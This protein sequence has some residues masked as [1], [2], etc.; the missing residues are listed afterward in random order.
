[1]A[2]RKQTIAQLA[3]EAG[4]EADEALILLWDGGFPN[5]TGPNDALGKGEA[6]RARRALGLATRRELQASAYWIKRLGL[7]SDSDLNAVLTEL[8]VSRPF[9]GRRLRAKAIHRLRAE[10]RRRAI[11]PRPPELLR[12]D[13]RPSYEPLI[14]V[15][16]GHEQNIKPLRYEDVCS[17]HKLLVED[18]RET[19]DPIE[20]SG[21]RSRHLLESALSRP[22]TAI[23][24]ERKYP[25][26]EMAAAALLHS[27]VHDHPFHNGNKR[28]ALVSMLVLLDENGMVLTCPED[29]L[30]KLV[31]KLAQHAIAT[32]PRPELADREVLVVARWLK[33]RVRWIEKGDRSLSWRRLK[34]ILARYDCTFDYA[35]VGNRI[36]ITRI[37]HRPAGFFRGRRTDTVRTQ[38]AYA[39]DGTEVAK[40]TVNKIRRDLELDDQ[41]GVDSAA[42]YDRE[43]TAPSEFIQRYRKTLRRLAKL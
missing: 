33:G 5:V 12:S 23:G 42:F 37:V 38:T 36:N 29:E 35:T 41:H 17:I 19:S 10:E 30:F 14:W 39:G 1:M 20:P 21:V 40:N 22:G 18:F 11:P 31:L 6:N 27:L 34:H 25:T 32:G 3:E 9:E 24:N 13:G 15:T 16:V 7:S 43:D 4:V 26:V 28:T 8:G 2:R